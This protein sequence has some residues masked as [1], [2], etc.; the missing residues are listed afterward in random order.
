[1]RLLSIRIALLSACFAIIL[2]C[3]GPP[4]AYQA[5]KNITNYNKE[6]DTARDQDKTAALYVS[7][8][9]V[10][11]TPLPE[12]DGPAWLNNTLGDTL[13]VA[14]TPFHLVMS[15]ILDGTQVNP[16][17]S[18]DMNPKL[19]VTLFQEGGT[20][21]QALDRVA[22]RTNYAYTVDDQ[23][24]K[25]SKFQ[26][27]TFDIPM[28]AGDYSYLVGKS[29]EATSSASSSSVDTSSFDTDKAQYA[30]LK[31]ENLNAFQDI[32][33]SVEAIVDESSLVIASE[34][35]STIMV[36][37][38]PDRMRDV[39]QHIAEITKSLTA[40]I[41]L[42]IRAIKT[43]KSHNGETGLDWSSIKES[44]SKSLSF[45]GE[46]PSFFTDS[47]PVQ[48]SALR[49]GD[50]ST[51][52][53][54]IKAMEEQASVGTVMNHRILVLNGRV[55][56]LNLGNIISYV[57]ST[58]TTLSD[59][60]GTQTDRD[61]GVLQD[62]DSLYALPKIHGD[63]VMVYMSAKSSELKPLESVG[64]ESGG[65][66]LPS[67]T[68]NSFR[69]IQSIKSGSTVVAIA[70]TKSENR[71]SSNSPISSKWIPFY[72]GGQTTDTEIY[73]FITPRIVRSI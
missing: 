57:A 30:N 5:K 60:G 64:D 72:K 16:I 44:T 53:T 32:V 24:I 49:I 71:A 2:G 34:S 42:E 23:T 67:V 17:Y 55:T 25:W 40:Q 31:A 3:I 61:T 15:W 8:P 33:Q 65:I 26:T 58:T 22:T 62:G 66:Q 46:S 47:V 51:L 10:N 59:G 36:K 52:T 9:H 19:A 73:V 41:I 11:L 39:R 37:T 29:D 56:D 50:T 45:F 21:R 27:E 38:T 4:A 54:L 48:I 6:I 28:F 12:S 7:T 1:M 69:V 68:S 43:V 14:S 18:Y 63:S 13:E 20:I 70:S 35:S